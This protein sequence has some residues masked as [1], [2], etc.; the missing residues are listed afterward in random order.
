M[1]DRGDRA[2][3][4]NISKSLQK[5][6]DV[7]L[8][9]QAKVSQDTFSGLDE[10]DKFQAVLAKENIQLN[11]F[12]FNHM[13]SFIYRCHKQDNNDFQYKIYIGYYRKHFCSITSMTGL[14][15]TAYYCETCEFPYDSLTRH[16]CDST[17]QKC[18]TRPVCQADGKTDKQCT[19][20]NKTFNNLDCYDR[21]KAN[22]VCDKVKLCVYCGKY[23][24]KNN[25]KG[26]LQIHVCGTHFVKFA[27]PSNRKVTFA[28][29]VS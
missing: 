21:H 10:A 17:C 25:V 1:H 18:L 14:F 8:Q 27:V 15:A 20:C 12:S 4:V 3:G 22:K 16:H 28:M 9:K 19:E 2:K 24:Q 23:W 29:S 7:E 26:N 5:R 13:N 11:I 6:L